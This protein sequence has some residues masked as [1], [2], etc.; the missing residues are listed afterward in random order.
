MQLFG[1][2]PRARVL[3]YF[4]TRPDNPHSVYDI[5]TETPVSRASAY[6]VVNHLVWM[7]ILRKDGTHK[8]CSLYRLSLNDNPITIC[9]ANLL[10]A[11]TIESSINKAD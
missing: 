2:G 6:N 7:G 9:L 10:H 5:I 8:R 1:K 11:S 4:L 3:D